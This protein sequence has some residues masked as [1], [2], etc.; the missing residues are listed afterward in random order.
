MP[1][2]S[3]S[4][5]CAVGTAR[6]RWRSVREFPPSPRQVVSEDIDSFE[7]TPKPEF[8]GPF[9]VFNEVDEL[10]T[11]KKWCAV[12]CASASNTEGAA[13]ALK[14]GERR[15]SRLSLSPPRLTPRRRPPP[16]PGAPT[17]ASC[18]RRWW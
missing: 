11:L 16:A 6:G 9:T 3:S 1:Y 2:L 4:L 10:A 17:C 12:T 15:H 8:P 7:Y 18:S 5:A 14:R 13:P